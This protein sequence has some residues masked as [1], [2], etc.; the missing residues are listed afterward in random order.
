MTIRHCW[1]KAGILPTMELSQVDSVRVPIS[2]LIDS[3]VSPVQ[4]PIMHVERQVEEA[5]NG[6]VSTGGLQMTNHMNIEN[7]LN[8]EAEHTLIDNTTDEE[9][10]EAIMKL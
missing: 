4:D 5:L 2:S 3:D 8:L 9:I 10:Y 6:L 1:C 7:L